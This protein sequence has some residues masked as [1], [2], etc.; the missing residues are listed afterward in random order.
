M[1]LA[2]DLQDAIDKAVKALA[3]AAADDLTNKRPDEIRAFGEAAKNFAEAYDDADDTN[4]SRVDRLGVVRTIEQWSVT[5]PRDTS[6][7]TA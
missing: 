6:S 3:D 4:R 7:W 1:A 5:A 2:R